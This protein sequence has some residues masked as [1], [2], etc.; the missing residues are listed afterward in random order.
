MKK[1]TIQWQTKIKKGGITD[2]SLA[3]GR[4]WLKS[5]N[6]PNKPTHFMSEKLHILE[7]FFRD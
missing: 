1:V 4:K 5:W 3:M 7:G 6:P 2:I